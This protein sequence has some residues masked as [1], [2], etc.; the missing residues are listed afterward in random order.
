MTRII[1]PYPADDHDHHDDVN[2]LGLQA[3]SAML[4]RSAVDR[5]RV[6]SLGLLGIG[7]LVG[8]GASATTPGTGSGGGTTGTADCPAAIPSE[9]AGPYPADGSVASGQSL[10]VLTRS[11]IVRSDLRTSLSTGHTAAGVPLTVILKLVN[12]NS[13]CAALSGYAVYLWHCTQSG[14]Y[15]MYS[16]AVVGEDYLRGVQESGADG[17]VTFQTIFPACYSGRWPHI[18][19]EIYPTLASATSAPGKI[20]TS[21]LALPRATCDAVYATSG[22]SAS[23]SN[24]SRVS[25]ATD[26]VFGD[27]V[28]TQTPTMSG[29]VS[30]GYTA[31]LTVG[32]AR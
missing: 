19:F 2:N 1:T 3:D 18:H 20:Q 28:G 9:T 5:R 8:C 25:L 22:Y 15:S 31:N 21:Q 24:L 17:T 26:N 4:A 27:G 10:N 11:G 30:A 32:L 23:V 14:E 7:L 13:S 16:S 6:L 29:S 12:T